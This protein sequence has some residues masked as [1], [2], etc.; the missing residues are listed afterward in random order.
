MLQINKIKILIRT[1][2][3]DYGF[4]ES[5]HSGLNF[6][7]SEDNTCGKS[8]ILV[9]IYY[10]LGIEEIIG[11]KGEK[12]LTS[13]YKSNIDDDDKSFPVLEYLKGLKRILICN[14]LPQLKE[15][16]GII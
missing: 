7:A 9:A 3:G 4:Q 16:Q 15:E 5:F 13:V 8:S 6:I 2:N 10:C 12:V 14:Y 11:G 1:A